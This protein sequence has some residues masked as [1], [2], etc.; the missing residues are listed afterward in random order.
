MK[1]DKICIISLK[2]ILNILNPLSPD[3]RLW[4][5]DTQLPQYICSICGDDITN[6]QHD[7]EL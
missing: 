2:N 4:V 3:E 5:I 1:R 6:C 7:Q